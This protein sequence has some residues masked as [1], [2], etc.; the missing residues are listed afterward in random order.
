M[1]LSHGTRFSFLGEY[2][3]NYF[4][5]NE[6][7]QRLPVPLAYLSQR[8]VLSFLVPFNGGGS[9]TTF[10]AVV[11]A[12]TALLSLHTYQDQFSTVEEMG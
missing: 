5:N 1:E 8:S 7:D 9:L 4:M 6:L 3:S 2:M 11:D 12:F 10:V